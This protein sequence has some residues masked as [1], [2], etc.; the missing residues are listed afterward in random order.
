M[1]HK[2]NWWS[3]AVFQ[4]KMPLFPISLKEIKILFQRNERLLSSCPHDEMQA[5]GHV[6]YFWFSSC[7]GSVT[8]EKTTT[9]NINSIHFQSLCQL[10]GETGSTL[11]SVTFDHHV[12]WGPRGRTAQSK[13]SQQGRSSYVQISDECYESICAKF[14]SEACF[15]FAFG[16]KDARRHGGTFRNKIDS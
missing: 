3:L 1:I 16:T 4:M 11:S 9:Q 6:F 7:A 13:C 10:P 12:S 14:H 2:T 15:T 8:L 5:W